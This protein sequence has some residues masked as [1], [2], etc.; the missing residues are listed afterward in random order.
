MTQSKQKVRAARLVANP[1]GWTSDFKAG[2]GG[3]VVPAPRKRV[4]E[5]VQRQFH[6]DCPGTDALLVSGMLMPT[7]TSRLFTFTL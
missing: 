2:T 3:F 7:S 1:D 6:K 4:L 5:P